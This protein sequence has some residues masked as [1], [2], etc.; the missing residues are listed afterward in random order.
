VGEHALEYLN[1]LSL[2]ARVYLD[3]EGSEDEVGLIPELQ[4][5]VR[6]NVIVKLNSAIGASSKA[7]DWAPE[8]SVLLTFEE[9]PAGGAPAAGRLAKPPLP[10]RRPLAR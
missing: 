3:V 6:P 7:T 5:Y 2:A 4:W 1:R 8:V 10:T 9:G